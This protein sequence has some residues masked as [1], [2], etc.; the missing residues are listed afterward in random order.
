MASRARISLL[1]GRA[2]APGLA[3]LALLRLARS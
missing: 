3:A 2:A 1:L